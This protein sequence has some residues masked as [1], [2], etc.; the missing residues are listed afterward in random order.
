LSEAKG[1][2]SLRTGPSKQE[3]EFGEELRKMMGDPM[4]RP[5]TKWTKRALFLAAFG[6]LLGCST[7]NYDYLGQRVPNTPYDR[8][9][10]QRVEESLRQRGLLDSEAGDPVERKRTNPA[11]SRTLQPSPTLGPDSR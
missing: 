4:T 5:L 9:R 10:Y 2:R 11:P 8:D 3:R 7:N 1:E 6:I